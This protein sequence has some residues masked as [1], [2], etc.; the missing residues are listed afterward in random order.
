MAYIKKSRGVFARIFASATLVGAIIIA[1]FAF[2]AHGIAERTYRE[3][4]ERLLSDSADFVADAV[5]EKL[6]AETLSKICAVH[7][8]NTGIRTT[9]INAKGEVVVD[10]RADSE[11][12]LNHLNRAEIK[13]A[14][15][16]EKTFTVRYSDTLRTKMVY[17]AVPA[18]AEGPD[19]YEY[20][21]R[22]SMPMQKLLAAKK[23]IS[24]EIIGLSL[25]AIVMAAAFSFA[26]A[27]RISAPL[28]RLTFAADECARG[29]FDAPVPSSDISEIERLGKSV[30]AMSQNLKKRINSLYKRNCE[31]D[32]MFG[33][34]TDCVFICSQKGV[35][36]KFNN[37]CAK[38]F[39]LDN[40]DG[41][42]RT[43]EAFRNSAILDAID[44]T[45]GGK[46]EVR[47]DVEISSGK[48]YALVGTLLPYE[49]ATPRAL[50]VMRDVSAAK[51]NEAL[52]REFVAGVS[53]ELKTPITAIK[54]AAETLE[55]SDGNADDEKRF[56]A[57]IEKESDR[58]DTLVNDMLLLS[59]IEFEKKFD[60]ENFEYFP[61]RAA[62]E[63]SVSAHE[64]Q[65]LARR[66]SVEIECP[67]NL[68]VRGDFQ[69]IRLAVSN[70]V[71][72]A[73]KYAGDGAKIK[74]SARIGERGG[75]KITVSDNGAGI[76][77]D[78]LP[79]VFERFYRVDKGRSRAM[80]G[81][82]L[83]LALV[84]HI[85]ILHKGGVSA[86]SVLGKGSEF[87]I[88]IG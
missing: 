49:S 28:K 14:I 65:A 7:D 78:A 42:I 22:Q 25:A 17:A 13:K 50:F 27:K 63:E 33:Y 16:G 8:K 44:E 12:M 18:G 88:T 11:T 61:I 58:M 10:S 67:E 68:Q 30:L 79:H 57:I 23:L 29:N 53:H 82:G 40:S 39:G 46:G 80:G 81:T 19:G 83:G 6:P 64:S 55:Y 4:V 2:A 51:R 87:S 24:A 54:M 43:V 3:S 47:R 73:V 70:L 26:L 77:P 1:A 5:D 38:L 66:D 48:T 45:F 52:R 60:A 69:L 37:A 31:L 59:K 35:L 56:V 32:E 86:R 72:N 9:L 41:K 76:P 15:D 85:A 84:K 62:I 20:C 74:V 36:K 34:M 75:V 21:V 71:G